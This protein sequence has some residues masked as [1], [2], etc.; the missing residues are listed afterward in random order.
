MKISLKQILNY[1]A[2]FIVF[3]G[4]FT[5][6]LML[7][8]FGYTDFRILYV[9][10]FAIGLLWLPFL[11]DGVYINKTFLYLFLL[12]ILI[13]ILDVFYGVNS[14]SGL[15]KQLV[16]ISSS[17]LFFYLLFWLNNYDVKKLFKIY[18]NIAFVVALIGIIQEISFLLKFKPGYDYSYFIPTWKLVYSRGDEGLLAINSILAEP[19]HFCNVM[20]PAFFVSVAAFF[21]NSFKFQKTW[22]RIII[23]SSI[24]LS[25]STMGYVGILLAIVMFTFSRL[26]VRKIFIGMI[27]IFMTS[28]LIYRNIYNV[29]NRIHGFAQ[30]LKGE[31]AVE[32]SFPSVFA[33]ASN[34]L[35][36][37]EVF[38][39]NPLFGF[40]LG[41]YETSY[42]K[43]IGEVLDKNKIVN[44]Y[45]YREAGSLFLR[46]LS[47]TGL[48]GL[49]I[50]LI[51]ILKF[52]IRRISNHM[53]YL[54]IIN[55]A[56]LLMFLIKL[57]R[58][59]HYFADGFFFFVWSYYFSKLKSQEE[60]NSLKSQNNE[61]ITHIT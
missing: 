58:M 41:S 43:Y 54:W 10:I 25:F 22:K 15:L 6:T 16:G 23:I 59:G 9:I 3:S 44:I 21:K 36:T 47:E 42:R 29:E 45:N 52:R 35:V 20:M 4:G 32:R 30:I 11:A 26:S 55:N 28:F 2:V 50:M 31:I 12:I 49:A 53:N 17:V 7:S 39:R 51:F 14:F 34:T 5:Y 37:Y 33:L 24:S 18:L 38:K 19:A 57:I 8:T 27:I 56:I 13:S 60:E 40:G 61:S 46:L 48:L 1:I